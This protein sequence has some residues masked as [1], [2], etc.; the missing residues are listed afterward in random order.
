MVQPTPRKKI[1]L[2]VNPI[3][4]MGGKVGLKGTDGVYDEAV[5]RG[6]VPVSQAKANAFLVKLAEMKMQGSIEWH[7][8]SG[9]MGEDALR[10][11][12]FDCIVSYKLMGERTSAEDT[13]LACKAFVDTGCQLVIF[14]GGDGTARD[15]HGAVNNRVPILGVPSG[16]KMHSGVFGVNPEAA[17][18]LTA[19]W[20]LGKAGIQEGELMDLDEERYRKGE[21]NIAHFGLA[22][23]PFEPSYVQVGKEMYEAADD[24][25]IRDGIANHVI[26]LMD[27]IPGTLYILGPGSTLEHIGK[28]IGIDKT[29]LGVDCVVDRQLVAKD[30]SEKQILALLEKHPVAKIVVSPI[31][32][33]GFFFGRGNLQISSAVVKKVNMADIIVVATPSKLA[34]TP[35]LRVDFDDPEVVDKFK[36]KKYIQVVVGYHTSAFR[37]LG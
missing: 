22:L 4:G 37:K 2:V 5:S 3:S 10:E 19:E 34:H 33:Q 6:A 28:R 9:A 32:A 18:E 31:G 8:A 20:L 30:A 25:D 7:A 12:G 24:E 35:D 16:V 36:I 11:A 27:K 14:V 15:V 23:T 29:L 17:A 26:E 1:G 21:W 13:K